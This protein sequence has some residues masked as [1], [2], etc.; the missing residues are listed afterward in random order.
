MHVS[1]R[2]ARLLVFFVILLMGTLTTVLMQSSHNVLAAQDPL[3][4][5]AT[6]NKP[7]YDI[8]E[9]V[10]ILGNLTQDGSPVSGAL[11]SIEVCDLTGK[12]IT[13]RTVPIGD[14]TETWALNITE[15]HVT[16]LSHNP[17]STAQIGTSILLG[18]T[19]ENLQ[20]ISRYAFITFS[21]YDG[22][23]IPVLSGKFSGE[24]APQGTIGGDWTVYIPNWA[25]PGEATVYCNA[26]SAEPK[27]GGV[28]Y[29]PE[30]SRH[31]YL[32]LNPEA[33]PPYSP[34][35]NNETH[36]PGKY[37][38][39]L[40]VSPGRY[41]LPGE[42]TV[43]ANGRVSPIITAYAT[44]TFS[45]LN[46]PAPPQASFTYYPLQAYANMTITFDASSSS[47][48]GYNDTII[49]YE[50]TINDP[51]NP[52]HI[53][54]EGTYTNPPSPLAHHTFEYA[55]TYMVELNVTDNEGLWSTTS[56]PVT[57]FPEFG[58]TANFTWIPTTAIL[59]QIVMF[60]A[61]DS[62][63]GWSASSQRWSPIETYI[64]N[65]SDG[66]GDIPETDPIIYHIF[67]E[68]G[69]FA[70]KLTVIDAD[71]RTDTKSHI[72]EVINM[73]L[74]GDITGPEGVPDGRVDMRD[75]S[76]AAIRF[77]AEIGDPNYDPR[78]DITGP[79]YL[80]PDGIINM[81]DISLIATHFGDHL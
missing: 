23:M 63:T 13:Q 19:V 16:D 4:I 5:T 80:V 35:I 50:W 52:A 9:E 44:T 25:S 51:Y 54:N 12:A 27:D 46:S 21:L 36:P 74:I 64:W 49:R 6:T 62:T 17:I 47:A 30:K 56:K 20:S 11:V 14:P 67:A 38:T 59:N 22:T 76:F 71:G 65:F 2:L 60:N 31:F 68:P 42:Y 32:T 58:P 73:T 7:A 39:T 29:T 34:P 40:R 70:V 18:V 28:P 69:N 43:Y 45:V 3:I 15:I 78:A 79:T 10:N 55:G 24:I 33:E 61:S 53:V 48:E 37:D 8:R 26:Y 66:T 72:I 57:I 1:S 41:F 75:I 77:G 81:R